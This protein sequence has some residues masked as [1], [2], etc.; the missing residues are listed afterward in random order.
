M[1]THHS[2]ARLW[3]LCTPGTS[4]AFRLDAD[5]VPRHVHW[6]RPLSLE[7]AVAVAADLPAE[8]PGGDDPGERSTRSRAACASG[9]RR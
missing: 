3:L 2:A 6:G 5:D 1:I 9:L 4:Y 8:D 7:Q